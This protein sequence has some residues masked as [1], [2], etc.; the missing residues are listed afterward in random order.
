[1]S[2]SL[3][4]LTESLKNKKGKPYDKFEIM[5]TH[6][7]KEELELI[8]RKWFY[9]YEFI[10][11][12]EKLTYPELPPKEAFYSQV[13]LEGISDEDYQHAQKVY[14]TF[15]CK[16]FSD[17][18]WLYLKTDVLLLAD[19]FEN[20]RKLSLEHYRLDPANYLTAASLAWDAM[21]LKTGVDLE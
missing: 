4:K 17:Y 16:D 1:M 11:S 13:R 19:I 9:P 15:N 5:K 21:M 20:F 3:E 6:F 18:H 7:S 10:D 12:S 14:K 2:G 8:G